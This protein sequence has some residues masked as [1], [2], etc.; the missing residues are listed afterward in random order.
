MKISTILQLA[1]FQCNPIFQKSILF[2]GIIIPLLIEHG[3]I[4]NKQEIKFI[5][6]T[7]ASDSRIYSDA[8]TENMEAFRELLMFFTKRGVNF[9][10]TS[11]KDSP[12]ELDVNDELFFYSRKELKQYHPEMNDRELVDKHA[13]YH[14]SFVRS[15]KSG[16]I[17]D[18]YN[19]RS[20]CKSKIS[21]E[22]AMGLGGQK[23]LEHVS[24]FLLDESDRN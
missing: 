19:F 23:I 14:N 10:P 21:I 20:V 15:L 12:H 22:K 4:I 24:N 16:Y 1:C 2:A 18:Y 6:M 3:A 7:V 9:F 5:L 8:N 13:E 11:Q 17:R